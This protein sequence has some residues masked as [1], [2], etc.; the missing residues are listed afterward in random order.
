MANDIKTA[1]WSSS[2][3]HLTLKSVAATW[4]SVEKRW[5]LTLLHWQR[6]KLEKGC[7]CPESQAKYSKIVLNGLQLKQITYQRTIVT[8]DPGLQIRTG[9]HTTCVNWLLRHECD[10]TLRSAIKSCALIHYIQRYPLPFFGALGDLFCFE[11]IFDPRGFAAMKQVAG[12]MRWTLA[13]LSDSWNP[14]Q[15]EPG[16]G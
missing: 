8:I 14:A 1:L 5:S 9:L 3:G 6:I 15:C 12:D 2:A 11:W 7:T 10:F 4:D 16:C 13:K